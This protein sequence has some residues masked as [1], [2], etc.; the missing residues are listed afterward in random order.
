MTE[1]TDYKWEYLV[2]YVQNHIEVMLRI[3]YIDIIRVEEES[4]APASSSVPASSAHVTPEKNLN[5]KKW[6]KLLYSECDGRIRVVGPLGER[7]MHVCARAIDRFQNFD[8]QGKG[9][10]VATGIVEGILAFAKNIKSFV[11]TAFEVER[12]DLVTYLQK[13]VVSQ[14]GKDYCAIVG[15]Y[16]LKFRDRRPEDAQNSKVSASLP[17]DVRD[18]MPPYWAHI[19]TWQNAHMMKRGLM[20]PPARFSRLLVSTGM[21]EGETILFPLIAGKHLEAIDELLAWQRDLLKSDGQLLG[22]ASDAELRSPRCCYIFPFCFRHSLIPNARAASYGCQREAFSSIRC[23]GAASR[24]S[25]PRKDG[26]TTSRCGFETSTLKQALS[27]PTSDSMCLLLLSGLFSAPP[28]L[29]LNCE[30]YLIPSHAFGGLDVSVNIFL[31]LENCF[32][33][34]LTS[35]AA[36]GMLKLSTSCFVKLKELSWISKAFVQPKKATRRKCCCGAHCWTPRTSTETP[37]CM[38]PHGTVKWRSMTGSCALA[39]IPSSTIV[40]G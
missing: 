36:R 11:Q 8:F 20:K 28:P 10:Y 35:V 5:E 19:S 39:P 6:L 4:S 24:R 16:L 23:T 34:V 13:E 9:N 30:N 32:A 12:P 15:D 25:H 33:F 17:D 1:S 21:F 18:M 2:K 38:W 31:P 22:N 27:A 29:S 40:T 26:C 14:Y 37:C 7:P 3:L